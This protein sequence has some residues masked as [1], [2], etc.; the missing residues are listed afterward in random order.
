MST[1]ILQWNCRGLFSNL[2]DIN[3]LFEEYNAACFCL[4]ETYLNSHNFNPFRRCNIFRKDRVDTARS[5]GGVA[6]ALPHSVPAMDIPLT[7]D[8]EAV[9]VRVCLDQVIT[10]CS[11]Y[12]PP[13]VPTAQREFEKLCD[14]LPQP[15]IILGDLNAHNPLWGSGKIDNRGKML[16]RVLFSRSLCLLNTGTPTYL[17]SA[18]QSLSAID[19]SLCSPSLFS[20]IDW[21][22]DENP[23]GSDH[24]PI[25]LKFRGLTSN[26]G[27]R[28]PRWKLQ[29]A[30]WDLF[31]KEANILTE[32][33]QHLNVEE[34]NTL[35]TNTII[36]AANRSIP[37]TK[38]NLPRRPKPW[39]TSDC[40]KTRRE[41]NRAWGI[42]RRYPTSTNLLLFKKARAK[43]R[44]T[45]RQAKKDSWKSFV[46]SLNSSTSSKVMWD[47]LRKIKGDYISFSVPLLQVNGSVCQ[48]IDEQANALGEHFSNVSNSS[49]YTDDFLRIKQNA[50]KQNISSGTGDR[51]A[52]N[53]PFTMQELLRALCCRKATAPGPDRITYSMLHHLSTA[54]LEGLLGFFNLVWREGFLPSC[55]KIATVIPLLKPGKEASDPAS[56]RPIALTSCLGKTFERMVNARLMYYLEEN[57]CLDPYQCGFRASRST[58]DHLLRLETTIREAF[59]RRQHC[60]SI[61]FD[62]E[63]AY[64]TTWRYGI[65]RDLHSLG[66]RGR[67]FRCISNFLQG[68]TFRV[69]LGSTLSRPFVQENGVPQGSVLSVTLFIVKVNSVASVIPPSI[70]YSLYVDDLQVSCS[71]S[72]LAVCERQLQLTLNKLAKWSYENGFRFSP[73][74]T[75]CIPFSRIRG[76]F[77]EPTLKMR[78]QEITVQ[79]EHKFLGV[80]FDKKLT[81]SAHIKNLKAKSLKSLNLL[82]IL[83]HRSWGA[84]R[85]TLHRIYTS[86]VR[87]RLDYA[88]FIYGSARPS[89]LKC[90][91]TVHHLGL[92]L[93]LGAFRTTPV[94]SLYVEA[95]EWSLE[96]RRFYLG[97][98]YGLRIRG[99]PQHPAL[100]CVKGTR[101]EQL[102]MNKP[103]AI[104]PFSIRLQQD[105]EHYAFTSY[106][107]PSLQCSKMIPPWQPAVTCDTSLLKFNKRESPAV[108][109]QQEFEL[110]K[111]S[112]G[113]H[114]EIYTDASKTSSAVSCAMVSGTYTKSHCLSSVLSIFSAEMYAIVVALNH[115]LQMSIPS[116]VIYTDSLSSV[117]AICNLKTHKNLLARRAQYLA[118]VVQGRGYT[119][120]LCWVPSHVGIHGNES[121]DRAAASAQG[122]DVTPFEIPLGDLGLQLK[123]D[124]NRKW[125][126]F[127]ETQTSNK[128]NTVKPYIG[129][130][131]QHFQ[132]RLH[133]VLSSRLRV[134]HTFLTHGHL[135][136][137]DDAPECTQCGTYLSVLHILISCPLFEAHRQ[138]NFAY[139][140]KYYLPL[141]PALLLGD[142]ALIPFESVFQFLR[143]INAINEL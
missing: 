142:E 91:D 78:G 126:D 101:F 32:S 59:I 10:V 103:S 65:L 112:F 93:V 3:D 64:D 95:N 5:S 106:H 133:E 79:D 94:Q 19:I 110:L 121:A 63:K 83:S 67:L 35:V 69:Q 61:F 98:T 34:A 36:N 132:N 71:S 43:A 15:F 56:Y 115:V 70:M 137:E 118:S 58:S 140:Y 97:A 27:T 4:Q 84:D 143:A 11:L 41:Q 135:L 124:I 48:S 114:I 117:H 33:F 130:S 96:R 90:L 75:V 122:N 16:E 8:L 14:Q 105:M 92:R 100:P 42:F 87:S 28:P 50:E 127:W 53:Q 20:S 134:G 44:W 37:Q 113:D 46:S 7:T 9:A 74:K 38:G 23:R 86:I 40:E 129:K 99:Y 2:D 116:S 24:F 54:S 6:I 82:K 51:C 29:Q 131:V 111:D 12:L 30:D 13:S 119:L 88:C 25:A 57:Q 17:N 39:W 138:S 55:W 1:S 125:Q 31:T 45:R 85:E 109:I 18:T 102:F 136:R 104:A 62:L 49:H 128:L 73:S 47:R 107:L 123:K 77:P 66:V 76:L 52:Y 80:I 89:V 21:K 108:E 72:S 120:R 81:F 68:R 26:I 141:H 22:V 60:V 139:F